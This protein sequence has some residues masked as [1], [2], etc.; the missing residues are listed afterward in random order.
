MRAYR[1][2]TRVSFTITDRTISSF[3]FMQYGFARNFHDRWLWKRM[4]FSNFFDHFAVTCEEQ[5]ASN[6]EG[7]PIKKCFT[8]PLWP[9]D[10]RLTWKMEWV[11]RSPFGFYFWINFPFSLSDL[12]LGH[13]HVLLLNWILNL[14]CHLQ[15]ILW[16]WIFGWNSLYS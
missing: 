14:F 11:R 5:T 3:R 8:F 12:I 10:K 9:L 2:G 7:L 15:E 4:F 13:K 6:V 1:F 16:V